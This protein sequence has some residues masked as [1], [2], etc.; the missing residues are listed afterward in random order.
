ML[1]SRCMFYEEEDRHCLVYEKKV[2]KEITACDLFLDTNAPQGRSDCPF[3][4]LGYLWTEEHL[5][6][7]LRCRCGA[8]MF[9]TT[10]L[11][12]AVQDLANHLLGRV[13]TA[14]EVGRLDVK[15]VQAGQYYD[16]QVYLVAVRWR[17]HEKGGAF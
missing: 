12:G 6:T 14:E 13:A 4:G 9:F 11:R 10:Q 8:R 3:C 7:P 15:T 16:D 2:Y 17:K 5:D 1:C